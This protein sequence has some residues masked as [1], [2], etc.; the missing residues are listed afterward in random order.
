MAD[1]CCFYAL[2]T[3]VSYKNYCGHLLAWE[4]WRKHITG[5]CKR[6]TVMIPP[7][8]KVDNSKGFIMLFYQVE[9]PQ[10]TLKLR[11]RQQDSEI[12]ATCKEK[13]KTFTGK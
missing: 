5:K 1:H 3:I 2:R 9:I 4:R 8:T 10:A 7:E 13:I 12:L 11:V 6:W